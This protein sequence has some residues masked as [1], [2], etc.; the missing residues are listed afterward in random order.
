MIK[1]AKKAIHAVLGEAN[2]TDEELMTAFID[3]ESC[4]S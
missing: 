3:A 4:D 2:V 1:A